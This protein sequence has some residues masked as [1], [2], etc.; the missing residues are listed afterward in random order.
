M[1]SFFRTENYQI[2]KL[3]NLESFWI[4]DCGTNRYSVFCKDKDDIDW[5]IAENLSELEAKCYIKQIY[6]VIIEVSGYLQ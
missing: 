1:T 6:E 5:R 3:D 4:E 2:L